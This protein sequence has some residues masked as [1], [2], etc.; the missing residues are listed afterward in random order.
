MIVVYREN[1]LRLLLKS[2]ILLL[3]AFIELNAQQIFDEMELIDISDEPDIKSSII[4]DPNQALLI[5]RSQISDLSFQ[6]NNKN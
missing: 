5:V 4:R 3:I 1:I 2:V 6:S